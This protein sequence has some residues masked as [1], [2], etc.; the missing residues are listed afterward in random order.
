MFHVSTMLPYTPNNKQQVRR[1]ALSSVFLLLH[2][3]RS[4]SVSFTDSAGEW[5][6]APVT[7]AGSLVLYGS[8]EQQVS[9]KPM[10]RRRFWVHRQLDSFVN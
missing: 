10:E 7:A 3:P 2:S 9:C 5:S 1:D 6:V 4:L 8:K